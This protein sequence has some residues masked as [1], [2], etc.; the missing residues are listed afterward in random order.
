MSC[1]SLNLSF[2]SIVPDEKAT[3]KS[4][5]D[6]DGDVVMVGVKRKAEDEP[7]DQAEME[8]SGEEGEGDDAKKKSPR[9]KKRKKVPG[10]RLPKN[11]LMQLNEIKPGLEFKMVTQSGPVHAPT[12]TMSVTVNGQEFEGNGTN[13]KKAKQ[14]AAEKALV[15][16][17][18]FRNASEAH[19]AM[20]RD[21]LN[22]DFTLD[23]DPLVDQI[24]M[25]FDPSEEGGPQTNG[26]SQQ[27]VKSQLQALDKNPVMLL[28]EMKPGLKY[29]F[30]SET[31]ESHSK[32]FVMS[33][34]VD[35][36]AFTGSGR[37]KKLAKA[38]AAQVALSTL[39]DM[40]FPNAP[41]KYLHFLKCIDFIFM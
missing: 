23:T 25:K 14:A 29:E 40:D 2:F 33:V 36:K 32:N 10:P 20:G 9:R 21:V 28:N 16:F 26:S 15:S 17:V 41:C 11:A 1:T 7:D 3:G 24:M 39:Y 19:L 22:G 4:M 6:T 13:K 30:V 27:S 5:I 34:G 18:Q 8:E 12:F 37:N 38:R 31:G 35:G